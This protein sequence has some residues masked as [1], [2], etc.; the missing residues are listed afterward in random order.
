MRRVLS[1]LLVLTGAS[2]LA[3]AAEEAV[4]KLGEPLSD[5]L[6]ITAIDEILAAPAA[7]AGKPVRIGGQVEGVCKMQGCWMDLVSAED[8]ALRVKVDDGVIVF[9]QEAVGYQ[10]T[11]EGTI[12]IVEMTKEKYIG[13]MRHVAEEEELEFDPESIGFGPYRIVQLRGQ[14]AEVNGG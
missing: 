12:E 14:G 5:G 10:A 6:E 3:A 7:W 11:A 1:A 9:P 4:T 2:V 8:T 13:W